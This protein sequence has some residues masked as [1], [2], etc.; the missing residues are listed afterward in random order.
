V[1]GSWVGPSR[2]VVRR[3]V[4]VWR[5][6]S[7]RTRLV[8]GALSV[9]VVAGLLAFVPPL[10][11]WL[12]ATPG[13]PDTKSVPVSAVK[14]QTP[15]H[16]GMPQWTPGA[17]T[18][19]AGGTAVVK[20]DVAS[21]GASHALAAAGAVG[22]GSPGGLD[23][24]VNAAVGA[25]DTS[26]SGT[27]TSGTS[28]SAG[29]S[30]ATAASAGSTDKV[31]FEVAGQD[32]AG[33]AG[34]RGVVFAVSR[35]DGV[36]APGRVA[37]DVD[38]SKF[39]NAY[40][41]DYAGRL[42]LVSLPGCVLVTPDKPE[43]QV[44]TP[45][46]GARNVAT[47]KV[48][49]VDALDVAGDTAVVGGQLGRSAPMR[50]L[51]SGG[52]AYA[53]SSGSSSPAGTY[54]ATSLS[55]TY[56]WAAGNNSGD[57][58]YSYPLRVPRS[59]GGPVPEVKFGYSAQSVDGRTLATNSQP[60][61]LG[62]GWDLS[63]SYVE[64]SFQSCADAGIGGSG[65][66]CWKAETASIVLNGHS[67]KII[68]QD[69]AESYR[70][71]DDDGS[72]VERLFDA[73]NGDVRGEYWK[74]TTTDGTQY[75]FGKGTRYS[76]D[77]QNTYATN[78]VEVFSASPGLNCYNANFALSWCM[79]GWRWNL[80]YVVDP[81]G[82]TMTLFYS[83]EQQYYGQYNNS[84]ANIYDHYSV[85]DHVDYGTRAGS[86]GV[87]AAPMRVQYGYTYRCLPGSVCDNNHPQSWPDTPIDQVCM[88]STW[89]PNVTSPVFFTEQKLSTVT[90]QV[91]NQA[92]L[93][94]RN[95]DQ[96]ATAQEF[97]AAPDGITALWLRSV[98]HTGLAGPTPIS[99]QDIY[100]DGV[101]F[102][103]RV[104]CGADVGV[105]C[106]YHFRVNLVTTGTG[107]QTIVN[108]L[109]T[110]C[111]R[112]SPPKPDQNSSRCF[113]QLFT[114]PDGD[115]VTGYGWFA[116]N[117]VASVFERDLTGGPDE[118][119]YYDYWIGGWTTP[120]LWHHDDNET[121]TMGNRTW[122][123]WR[124]Y[125]AVLTQHGL[126]GSTA[127]TQ[128]LT[129]YYRGMHG[130]RTDAGWGTRAVSIDD[131]RPG[132]VTDYEMYKGRVLE[133]RTFDAGTIVALSWTD[134][135]ATA[136]VNH[137]ASPGEVV[138]AWRVADAGTTTW[139]KIDATGSGRYTRTQ[140]SY[141]GD[142]LL[143]DVTDLGDTGPDNA[144][145][146]VAA[147]DD[148][149]THTDYAK[150]TS[151]YL[152]AYPSQVI[153]TS[154]GGIAGDGNYLSGGQ[155][156]YDGSTTLGT[157]PTRGLPTTATALA[158]VVG[159]AKT[160]KQA[161]R[162]DYDTSYGRP[163]N[164]YDALDRKTMT[165]YTPASGGPLTQVAVTNP[166]GHVTTTT[167]DPAW[168]TPTRVVDAN[169][170]TTN[171]AYDAMGRLVKVWLAGRD[172]GTQTP[173]LEYGYTLR[174]SGPNA[175]M[176]KKLSPTG[177]QISSY[178]I[179]DGRMRLRQAQS[180]APQANG[181]RIIND[182]VYD[183]RGLQV[184][185]S[186][187][188]NSAS[189]P[190]DTL[191]AF[192]DTDVA[193]QH[194]YGC[195][196][197]ARQTGDALWKNN[198]LQ[199]QTSTAYDGDRVS[200][201]PPTGGNATMVISNARGKT[202]ELRQY[203]TGTPSGAYQAT[204]YSYDRLSQLT[205]VSDPAGNQWLTHYDL[206]GRAD[207]TNDP[208]LGAVSMTYYEDGQLHSVTDARPVTVS[209]KYDGLGRKTSEWQGAVD[210][211]T[212]LAEWTYDTLAKGQLDSA[213]RT[214]GA[215]IYTAA[216][217]GYDNAYRPL[218]VA[219][220]IPMS[221]TS[222]AGTWTTSSTYNV[223]G[224]LAST[225]Y[226]AGGGL[227]AETVN[228]TYDNT[229]APLTAASALD[230]YVSA[231]SYYPSGA[232]YQRTLGTGSKRVRQ[233]TVIDEATGRL[234]QNKT[235]TE[236]QTTPGTWVEKL[237]ESYGYDPAGNVKNIQE[238]AAG[239][240]VSN[241]CFGYDA[242]AQ[243][244]EAWT[245][246]ASTCQ[247]S[248]TQS[249]VGGPDPY[250]NSYQYNT[251]GDRTKDIKHA[252]TGDTTRTYT[253]PTA[254]T[255][256]PHAVKNVVVSG[257]ATGT[258][259]YTYD[260]TGNTKTR[261]IVGKPGQTLTWDPEGHLA[262]I[263]DSTGTASYI[264]DTGGNRLIAKDSTGNTLY[265]PGT[266]IHRNTAGVTTGTRFY[267]PAVRT[268]TGGLTW[269]AADNHGTGQ[270]SIKASDLTVTRRKTDPFGNPR[271]A[272]PAWPTPHGF[273]DG[274]TDP[275]GLT[276]LGARRRR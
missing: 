259:A 274:D 94:Y 51:L 221:E 86:E 239:A 120:V 215:N 73:P 276:H 186:T 171:L 24:R 262:A 196:N 209:Y 62:E 10:L 38:Y 16:P 28:T 182:T 232:P 229:G 263:A 39:A 117:L 102:A 226:P 244:T 19:P 66:L 67:T 48:V 81:R 269:L 183:G 79:R 235:E 145:S 156:F 231:S 222:L 180:P 93:A 216:V 20:V 195:D 68:K 260:N 142:G 5:G 225:S 21:V 25:S 40:G 65:D 220:T 159:G 71:A 253:Y 1:V 168:G 205:T 275:T 44:Q 149:C 30:S 268:S 210:T 75:F 27:S 92:T 100:L 32:V 185:A 34:V 254:G 157:A 203:L 3:P 178:A 212:K 57:F 41:G 69:G 112:N 191:V 237:T 198:V 50:A 143:T 249:V 189:G 85:L 266:E 54:S 138:T 255:A 264:Y 162:V 160:W 64:R 201:T 236:N 61:V 116:K 106:L 42:R 179:Y 123:Q 161:S 233:T 177:N 36:A 200:V 246:T 192:N 218:G 134:P 194:R 98:T 132:T 4:L 99:V 37:L 47:V 164:I 150:N 58:T 107:A 31:R 14:P 6:W 90:T 72:R 243:L 208:D 88:S 111:T 190:T 125:S 126:A 114:P 224:S 7:L 241:Q 127:L 214:L 181:G 128:S 43:C 121:A 188:W 176:T 110:D 84:R 49:S 108:Y 245:T 175:V 217:T 63:A 199:W 167:V 184:K 118:G 202:T 242:L 265:L 204:T 170:K 165:V 258:D 211:G 267:G 46:G 13:G 172:P 9:V 153:T 219:V 104:D 133:S 273:V 52:T 113:P 2:R 230:T 250:W 193:N 152:L 257:A 97:P 213:K 248:P 174:S 83:R 135:T 131:T 252:G 154:C 197:L 87:V 169:N 261:N 206:R 140:N 18:W 15:V 124:G 11:D 272:Q 78:N 270:L 22:A 12:S 141:D 109:N 256:T 234:T 166:L 91:Y 76:G 55:P 29:S 80:D 130:D 137:T 151:G 139:T 89:C 74:I 228:Y 119:W 148:T 247:T 23:V 96:Y 207:S 101:A 59:L 187:L 223:D 173:N 163:V 158:S 45:V 146:G 238:T 144:N 82:N 103:N 105:L 271:G 240:T 60:S 33:R 56:S 136:L 147:S 70:L 155:I 115:R 26:T 35:A 251:I 95:I 17:V 122:S 227:A 77:P 8:A 53:L 129:M